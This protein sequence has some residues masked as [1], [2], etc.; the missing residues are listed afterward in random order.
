METMLVIELAKVKYKSTDGQPWELK[1]LGYLLG[2]HRDNS[3]LRF[4]I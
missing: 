4:S 3:N 2:R 1:Y